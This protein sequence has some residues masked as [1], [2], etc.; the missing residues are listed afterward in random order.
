MIKVAKVVYSCRRPWRTRRIADQ[1]AA[2]NMPQFLQCLLL[3][4]TTDIDMVNAMMSLLPQI[5][6]RIG[7][8]ESE[9]EDQIKLLDKLALH[10]D[11]LCKD[12]LKVSVAVGKSLLTKTLLGETLPPQW[13]DN[14]FLKRVRRLGCW[15]RW[16]AV[17]WNTSMYMTLV[18]EDLVEWPEASC[19]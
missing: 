17:S 13:H 18:S 14:G 6:R 4:H 10:R 19:F 12:V 9:W 8:D 7:V 11:M 2:Q 3:P 5:I 15:L 1:K 16:V